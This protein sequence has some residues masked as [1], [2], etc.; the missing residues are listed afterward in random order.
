MLVCIVLSCLFPVALWSS[1]GNWLT[2]LLS[3]LLLFVTFPNVSWSTSELR[4]R[5]AP[6]N[7]FKPSSKIFLLNV[8]RPYFFCGSFVF[9]M[10]CVWYAFA[11]VNCCL[12]VTCL[13]RAD[14]FA[15]VCDA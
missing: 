1:A 4:A 8:P 11:S 14:L 9:L 12:V 10:S 15:L 13:E 6:G 7:W 2:S 3:C 5:L